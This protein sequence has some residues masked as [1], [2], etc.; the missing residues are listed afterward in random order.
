[1]SESARKFVVGILL[2]LA[3]GALIGWFYGQLFWGLLAAT[4]LAL[5]WQ[6]RQL[7]SFDRALRT[8]N[9]NDFRVGEGIWEQIA[10]KYRFE[11]DRGLRHRASNRQLLREVRKSTNAM[12]D[13]AVVLDANNEIVACNRAAK[14]LAGLRRKKDR[15]QRID[16]MLR[17]PK[18]IK[19]INSN[20]YQQSVEIPSPITDG[21]WLTCRVVPYGAE[22]KLLLLRDV[23]ERIRLSK[24]RR[25]FVANASHELRSP[26]TVISGYLDGLAEAGDLPADWAK[27]VTQMRNQ[28]LRMKKILSEMLELSQLEGARSASREENINV[29]QLLNDIRTDFERPADAAKIKVEAESS[30]TLLGRQTE[31]ES[32]VVNL[33]SNALRHTPQNGEINLIW[34]STSDGADLIVK[35]T[36]DGVDPEHIP[37]LTER[38][39]RVDR[40]RSRGEGGIGLGLAIVKHVLVRHDAELEIKSEPGSGSEFRCIFPPDRV[41]VA[42]PTALS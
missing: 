7:L 1:M 39:F 38:F 35:D 24:M 10:A 29:V 34:K 2:F 26:L 13:G 31:I 32:V 20:D 4:A 30:A 16:N 3:A 14:G 40:G 23:T 42:A 37:R 27:P 25:D 17:D 15:G 18:L 41:K 36:G 9:F 19:L 11:R 22:Q 5:V 33:L 21:D 8:D 6:T 12:P 28:S